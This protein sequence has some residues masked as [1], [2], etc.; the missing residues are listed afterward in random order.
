MSHNPLLDDLVFRGTTPGDESTKVDR[1][2]RLSDL[3]IQQQEENR[4]LKEEL[5]QL[6]QQKAQTANRDFVQVSRS[7]MRKIS[8]LSAKSGGQV[9]LNVLMILAQSMNKQNAVMISYSVLQNLTKKTRPTINRAIKLLKD[10]NWI[11]VLKIGNANIYVLNSSVF[12]TDIAGKKTASFSAQ[13]ITTLEEQE[14]DVRSMQNV[15]LRTIPSFLED[16]QVIA[17]GLELGSDQL[18][19]PDQQD[20]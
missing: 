6:K 2:G 14:T 1:S 4:L 10:D 5:R 18:D 16:P 3:V 9:A 12:W 20:I 15:T 7:E 13:I 17:N 8:E 19:P 11:Q